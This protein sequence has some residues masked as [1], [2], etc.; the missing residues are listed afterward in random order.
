MRMNT[1]GRMIVVSPRESG[2]DSGE[3]RA[4]PIEKAY[5]SRSMVEM[6]SIRPSRLSA[7]EFGESLIGIGGEF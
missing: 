5:C 2:R 1:E 6:D 3:P 7:D 4:K